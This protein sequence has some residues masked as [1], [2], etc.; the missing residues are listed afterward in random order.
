MNKKDL[1]ILAVSLL[2]LSASGISQAKNLDASVKATE[3]GLGKD[4]SSVNVTLDE[5]TTD[6]LETTNNEN[7]TNDTNGGQLISALNRVRRVHFQKLQRELKEVGYHG[8]MSEFA[9]AFNREINALKAEVREKLNASDPE[10]NLTKSVM[11]QTANRELARI[12]AEKMIQLNISP[13]ELNEHMRNISEIEDLNFSIEMQH[14]SENFKNRIVEI[15]K[16]GTPEEKKAIREQIQDYTKNRKSLIRLKIKERLE[17]F[18][19]QRET[20]RKMLKA[21]KTSE[22]IVDSIVEE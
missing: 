2:L 12:R 13:E 7:E 6:K 21:N 10:E 18:R 22:E 16:N 8:E 1:T 15:A 14:M 5:D 9:T 4:L 3:K 17:L 19:L 11:I 20:I